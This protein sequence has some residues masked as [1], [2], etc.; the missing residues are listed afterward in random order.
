MKISNKMGLRTLHW[1]KSSFDRERRRKSSIESP[2]LAARVE[3]VS[4]PM[5]EFANS[6]ESMWDARPYRKLKIVPELPPTIVERVKA[7]CPS[8]SDL[9]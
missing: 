6:L 9:V 2:M 5:A 1:G 3:E 8:W 7:A 4:H